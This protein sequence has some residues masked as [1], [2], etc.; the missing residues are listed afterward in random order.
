MSYQDK[1]GALIEQ[2]NPMTPSKPW[3]YIY[4]GVR[5][6]KT[7]P[8]AIVMDLWSIDDGTYDTILMNNLDELSKADGWSVIYLNDE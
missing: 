3:L 7:D 2:R 1:P 6:H 4:L 5:P 8:R